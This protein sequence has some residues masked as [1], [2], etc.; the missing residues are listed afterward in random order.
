MNERR[1]VRDARREGLQMRFLTLSEVK[2]DHIRAVLAG[3]NGNKTDA[4]FVLGV[5]RRSLY[6]MV[7]R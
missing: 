3:C 1:K 7:K 2:R 4:A 5:D 6:R